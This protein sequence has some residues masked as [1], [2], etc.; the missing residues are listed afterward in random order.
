MTWILYALLAF[1]SMLVAYV[2]N[3]IVVLFADE[4][5]ELPYR[6]RWWQTYDNCLDIDWMIYEGIVPK[7]FR[8]DFNKHYI[9]HMEDKSYGLKPGYVDIID[10]NFTTKEKIQRYFCRLL[11]LYRNTAY[12]FAYEVL[13]REYTPKDNV[14]LKNHNNSDGNIWLSYIND[15]R[16]KFDKTWSLFVFKPWCKYFN[17]RIYAGWKLKGCVSGPRD[18]AM[19]A[20]HINPFRL[21]H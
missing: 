14:V 2:T 18:K 5:G 19:I 12:G 17:I 13:G 9:Y 1:I 21:R 20:F 6:L 11:W 8:Y 10:P 15:D 16:S 7:I 3:P 4:K